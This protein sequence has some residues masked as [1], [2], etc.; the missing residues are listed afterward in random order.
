VSRGTAHGK[1]F[2]YACLISLKEFIDQHSESELSASINKSSAVE[3]AQRDFES[4]KE[5]HGNLVRAAGTA[6]AEVLVKTE[7]RLI[8][9]TKGLH[10]KVDLSIQPDGAGMRGDVRDILAVRIASQT[11]QDWAIGISCKHNHDAVKHPRISPSIN[12]G[13]QW[14]GYSCDYQYWNDIRP[15]FEEI[16][17]C[18]H[19]RRLWRDV[20][21]KEERVYVP[22]LT[23]V[24]DQIK[25]IYDSN[26]KAPVANLLH[27]LIGKNDFYKAIV[28]SK[29]RILEVQGFNI[30]GTLGLPALK[31]NPVIKVSQ[32]ALPSRLYGIH[33]V[34]GSSNTIRLVMDQGWQISMR[35]HSASKLVENSLKMDIRLEGIPT[36]IFT[37]TEGF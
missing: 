20:D 34:E 30:N 1:A 14:L 18:V 29:N 19:E 33:F 22:L 23:A 4:L 8:Y 17:P 12:I 32:L 21:W 27:Y 2:E 35:I 3:N 31:K 9:R 5:E 15:V 28:R 11:D 13:K 7:P 16:Q 26:G 37:Q 10:D 36:H 25:R 6:L 24:R